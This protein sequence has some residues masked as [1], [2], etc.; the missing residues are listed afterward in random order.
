M[1]HG[2]YGKLTGTGASSWKRP[3]PEARPLYESQSHIGNSHSHMLVAKRRHEY[4]LTHPQHTVSPHPSHHSHFFKSPHPYVGDMYPT[5]ASF[6]AQHMTDDFAKSAYCNRDY[7]LASTEMDRS[8]DAGSCTYTDILASHNVWEKARLD[9]SS[10]PHLSRPKDMT[11]NWDE[12]YNDHSRRYEKPRP[13]SAR[14]GYNRP[15]P[16]YHG[17]ERPKSA[18]SSGRS[19]DIS[20]MRDVGEGGTFRGKAPSIQSLASSDTGH[21]RDYRDVKPKEIARHIPQPTSTKSRFFTSQAALQKAKHQ[22]KTTLKVD[23][24][25]WER[26]EAGSCGHSAGGSERSSVGRDHS[27]YSRSGRSAGRR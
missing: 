5:G 17:Y 7:D 12:S 18:R 19:S 16:E 6:A 24:D 13:K 3:P 27:K 4:E 20:R 9:K 22:C 23:H 15:R 11:R 10:H 14:P 25:R 1:P 2:N 21:G 8:T 26:I